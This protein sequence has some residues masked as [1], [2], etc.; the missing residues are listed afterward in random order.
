MP[1]PILS[2][3]I[4]YVSNLIH[5]KS[6]IIQKQLS[7]L[8]SLAQEVFSGIR[9]IKSYVQADQFGNF[10]AE[11]SDDY[12]DKSLSLAQVNALFFPLMLVLI[13]AS[14]I[15]VIYV[16]GVQVANGTITPGNIAEFVIY[17]NMLTWPVTAIGWIAS[18]IQQAEASQ[19]RINEFLHTDP[20][21]Q[22]FEGGI[23]GALE[24][25]IQ[26]RDV[27]FTYPDTGIRALHNINFDIKAG[28]RIAIVGRTASGKSTVADL[29]LRMYDVTE[30]EILLDGHNIGDMDVSNLRQRIGYV[31]QDVFLFSD[32][33]ANNILFGSGVDDENMAKQYAEY[34]AVH[35]DIAGLPKAYQTAV[36]ERGV[37]LSGGQKQRVAIAR[38]FVK[39]PDILILDDCL[40]AVD[41]KTERKIVDYLNSA[42]RGKTSIVI[43]HRI[44]GALEFDRIIVL[45]KGEI[46]EMGTHEELVE[47]QGL[48]NEILTRQALEDEFAV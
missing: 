23:D 20:A 24:G 30:G 7:Q 21:I 1:L 4:Y 9:V 47:K 13:G 6:S 39:Q 32:T 29:I 31:P 44:L 22:K 33:I 10:F 16:G 48:Y 41:T 17:V 11:E 36:G 46:A 35:D 26:F 43:T 34:A 19:K 28:E 27:S 45:E 8:N 2:I 25:R 5:K 18:I 42:L 14:T 3:S 38:A 15:L 40:S 12:K 37:T